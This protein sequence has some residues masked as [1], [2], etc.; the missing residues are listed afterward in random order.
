VVKIII[1]KM[2]RLGLTPDNILSKWPYPRKAFELP[3]TA[4][5]L[6]AV[7]S[8]AW[9]TVS[10]MLEF[11]PKLVQQYDFVGQTALHFCAKRGL[12]KMMSFLIFKKANFDYEDNQGKTALMY[13]LELDDLISVNILLSAGAYPWS[14]N[15]KIQIKKNV[16]SKVAY[17][18][19]TLARRLDFVLM[20]SRHTAKK[21]VRDKT[22]PYRQFFPHPWYD[23]EK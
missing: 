20:L 19:I 18:L 13:A 17:D 10:K 23:I 14:Q 4:N 16:R 22:W 5:F 8:K 12:H 2:H 7:K 9:K 21:I 1:K 15:T 3:D 11:E 6:K